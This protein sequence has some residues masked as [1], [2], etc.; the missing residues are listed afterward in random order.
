MSANQ[1][2]MC[3]VGDDCQES[4]DEGGLLNAEDI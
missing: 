1:N 3:N 2:K 4:Q